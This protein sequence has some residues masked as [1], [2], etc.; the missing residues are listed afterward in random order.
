MLTGIGQ[1]VLGSGSVCVYVCVHVHTFACICAACV[2]ML[3]LLCVAVD[4]I[5]FINGILVSAQVHIDLGARVYFK[6]NVT[7]HSQFP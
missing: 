6:I 3:E 5:I 2:Y 1:R 7:V 4:V